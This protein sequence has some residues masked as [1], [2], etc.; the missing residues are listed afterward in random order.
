MRREAKRP[1]L[2]GTSYIGFPINFH[3]E[4]G[5]VTFCSIELS[6][7]LEVSNGYQALS[8]EQVGNYGFL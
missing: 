2:V 1:L 3:E 5:I 8:P 4:S 7:P 6:A